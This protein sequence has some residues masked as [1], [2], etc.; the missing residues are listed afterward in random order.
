[1]KLEISQEAAQWYKEE[2][3]LQANQSLRL[4]VRYG[5]VGGLQPGFSLAVKPEQPKE[6]LTQ[7]SKEEITFYIEEEDSWYFDGHDLTVKYDA[8]LDEPSFDYNETA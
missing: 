5:G 3:E 6:P 7:T 2:L 1:M 8:S 4:F